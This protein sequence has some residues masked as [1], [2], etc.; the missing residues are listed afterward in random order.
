MDDSFFIMVKIERITGESIADV[1]LK[2]DPSTIIGL[3]ETITIL[4]NEIMPE[5][6]TSLHYQQVGFID[7]KL[8]KDLRDLINEGLF[9]TGDYIAFTE[10]CENTVIYAGSKFGNPILHNVKEAS[11]Q[12]REKGFYT[13]TKKDLE[14]LL[15]FNQ[16]SEI[17]ITKYSDVGSGHDSGVH[18]IGIKNGCSGIIEEI[19]AEGFFRDRDDCKSAIRDM[20]SIHES[21]MVQFVLPSQVAVKD[22]INIDKYGFICPLILNPNAQDSMYGI[23]DKVLQLNCTNLPGV[24]TVIGISKK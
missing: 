18:Y 1:I 23:Y 19:W 20:Q 16:L 4:Q 15:E 3:S 9:F 24:I 22:R 12:I 21:G 5:R 2:V 17:P 14:E 8:I 7:D 10:I 13:L 11:K 6:H